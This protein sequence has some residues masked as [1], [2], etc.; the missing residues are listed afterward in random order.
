MNKN[1]KNILI[2]G[3]I[4][5]V[6]IMAIGY[7]AFATNLNIA[8]TAETTS[9]WCIGFDSTKTND[10]VATEGIQGGATPTG[11]IAF[12]GTACSDNYKTIANLSATFTQPGD[13]IEYTLTIG[14]K[15][16]LPTAIKSI[17]VD[18]TNVTSTQTITKGN[19]KYI[20]EMP[21]TTTLAVNATTTMKVTAEFQNDSDVSKLTQAE[22][23]TISVKI[24]AAQDDGTGGFVEQ[25]G[26]T[27]TIYRKGTTYLANKGSQAESSGTTSSIADLEE[28]VDYV[29]ELSQL[30]NS[31]YLKHTIE[32]NDIIESFA[33]FNLGTEY[34]FQGGVNESDA[35]DSLIFNNNKLVME[36]IA[37]NFDHC[38]FYET[39]FNCSGNVGFTSTNLSSI[40]VS[41]SGQISISFPTQG[42]PPPGPNINSNGSSYCFN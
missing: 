13:K 36:S 39:N 20:I 37:S 19:I 27:G 34:C 14:N 18:N 1:Q 25:S 31:Y 9:A 40:Y 32:N 35:E 15:S 29:K 21:E 42:G 23:Q 33:C 4:A 38:S 17:S 22:S 30:R 7:A 3:L 24:I 16:T 12:D 10:L 28:N 6:L 11:A 2:G 26:F 5:I 41:K 8:G